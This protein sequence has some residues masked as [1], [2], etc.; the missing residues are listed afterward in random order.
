MLVREDGALT[1]KCLIFK[2][3]TPLNQQ[4]PLAKQEQYKNS[5]LSQDYHVPPSGYDQAH[6][7]EGLHYPLWVF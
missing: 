2:Q 7:V 5:I 3:Q 1:A 6:A 4:T